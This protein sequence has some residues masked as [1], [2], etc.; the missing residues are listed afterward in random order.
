MP[1]RVTREDPSVKAEMRPRGPVT[2]GPLPLVF[3]PTGFATIT[4]K[5]HKDVTEA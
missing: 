3:P 1:G 5:R 4:G 2:F